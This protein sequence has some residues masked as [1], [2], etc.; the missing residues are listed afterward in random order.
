MRI[1]P[2]LKLSG[3]ESPWLL[4]GMEECEKRGYKVEMKQVGY[5]FQKGG[6]K[7]LRIWQ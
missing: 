1:F 6:N 7:M 4:P 3:E 5:E 2:L